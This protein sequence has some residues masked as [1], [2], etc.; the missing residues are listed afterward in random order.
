MVFLEWREEKVL[1]GPLCGHMDSLVWGLS[2]WVALDNPSIPTEL[3]LKNVRKRCAM[4]VL[5]N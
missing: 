5:G 4:Q 2:C 1:L 3:P